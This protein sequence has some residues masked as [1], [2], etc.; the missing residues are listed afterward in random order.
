MNEP[1]ELVIKHNVGG[2]LGEIETDATLEFT[3]ETSARLRQG[4]PPLE[5]KPST[6]VEVAIKDKSRKLN[7]K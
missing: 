5:G 1:K 7:L 6:A 2:E 4:L 3:P